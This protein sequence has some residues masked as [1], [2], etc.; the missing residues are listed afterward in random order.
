MKAA[1]NWKTLTQSNSLQVNCFHFCGRQLTSQVN[2]HSK[3]WI[4]HFA[5]QTTLITFSLPPLQGFL[6]E[7][8]SKSHLVYGYFVL[9][10]G[11][12]SPDRFYLQLSAWSYNKLMADSTFFPLQ[13]KSLKVKGAM[14][15]VGGI[16]APIQPEPAPF[17]YGRNLQGEVSS[18]RSCLVLKILLTLV[19][20]SACDGKKKILE[21][22]SLEIWYA[23]LPVNK[24]LFPSKFSASVL[25]K[26]NL[27]T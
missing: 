4:L 24:Y 21:N 2:S 3:Q 26:A 12:K 17:S 19:L 18:H 1:L 6:S 20:I 25:A 10:I 22:V 14:V 11:T 8:G 27:P 23:K 7:K 5:L 9:I 15:T 16:R 13:L